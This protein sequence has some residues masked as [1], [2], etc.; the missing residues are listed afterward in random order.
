MQKINIGI[1][2]FGNIGSAV[3]DAIEKNQLSIAAN[4]GFELIVNKVCDVRKIKTSYSLTPNPYTL[5]EDPAIDIIVEAMGGEN[6]ALK[7]ILAALNAGKSVVTPNKEVIAKHLPEIIEVAQKNMVLVLFEAAV[8]GG[9][10]ILRSLKEDLAGNRISEVYGIVNGTTNYILTRM[11]EEGMEFDAAL[12]IAQVK[13]YAEP[14]PKADIEG[15][16]ASYKAAI[17]ASVAFGAKVDWKAVEFEGITGIAIEDILYASEIGYKIKLLAVAKLINDKLDVRVYPCLVPCSHPLSS[18]SD[19]YNAIYVKADPVGDLM[20]YGQGAGGGPTASAIIAD[21]IAAAR[22][23]IQETSYKLQTYKTANAS[24]SEARYYLR[25]Q[26]PD[27]CGVLAGISKTFADHDVS[28]AAVMQKETIGNKATIVI[29]LHKVREDNLNKAI[30]ALKKS[31]VVNK[32]CNLIR[33]I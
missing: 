1:I 12:K 21:I 31:A 33:I 28:I 23:K 26:A 17:L 32:I 29:L 5:I 8:G 24:Q 7:V 9:I 15:Y 6:P 4:T 22:S 10:P 13:G 14:N 27:T 3:A 18:V 19:N 25:L 30:A 16:D 11:T 2:G 20:Y